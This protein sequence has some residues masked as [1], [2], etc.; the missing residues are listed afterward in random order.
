MLLNSGCV[1]SQIEKEVVEKEISEQILPI[2]IKIKGQL[3]QIEDI[4]LLTPSIEFYIGTNIV[5]IKFGAN[6]F[7]NIK[8]KNTAFDKVFELFE[9]DDFKSNEYFYNPYFKFMSYLET[10]KEIE[11]QE[12]IRKFSNYKRRDIEINYLE[13]NSTETI[14]FTVLSNYINE[15]AIG[16]LK[17]IVNKET[18][19]TATSMS[20]ALK[21]PEKVYK[22][23]LRNS[24]TSIL[25]PEIGKLVNLRILDISG[26]RIK[27]I[28]SEIENCVYLKSI[29]AN[30]SQLS[31][32]PKSIGNLKRLRNL[33]F[34]YCKI[35]ELLEEFGK[36]ESLWSLS[37][38]SNQLSALPESISNLKNVQ[39]SSIDKNNFN[40]FPTEVLGLECVGN[41]WMH[42][43]NFKTIPKE[44][45]NLKGLH[46]FLI[47]AQE[48]ENIEEIKL[49]I[50][51]VRVIDESK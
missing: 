10:A 50:P 3:K 18:M 36:L 8:F 16:I 46:H 47:D 20:E 45:A 51:E 21:Q 48:I 9:V 6:E 49:L 14:K 41:L 7:Y 2:K 15:I 13:L 31:E 34:A 37:L 44:I 38:G 17:D 4:G 29:I 27:N 24:K 32:I 23:R 33:N 22:L 35:K 1:Q 5:E 12:Y 43:N 28:P 25:S 39:M 30:A 11:R 42:G 26:S 19:I 40:E